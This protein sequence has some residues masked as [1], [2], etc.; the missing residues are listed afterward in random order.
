VKPIERPT[1][2][3]TEQ[4]VNHSVSGVRVRSKI[5]P[6]VVEV[7]AWHPA[8]KE[9]EPLSGVSAGQGLVYGGDGGI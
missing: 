8:H 6:A 2:F 4:A 7:R 9:S 3:A 1:A 5:V